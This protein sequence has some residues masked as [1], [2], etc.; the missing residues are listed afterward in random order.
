MIGFDNGGSS[1]GGSSGL[2]L[3]TTWEK[4]QDAWN[5]VVDL[6]EDISEA[7]WSWVETVVDV[8]RWVRTIVEEIYG[9]PIE[10]WTTRQDERTCPQCGGLDGQTWE[11]NEGEYPPAH[12]NCRCTREFAYTEWRSREVFAWERQ[13]Q[14]IVTGGWQITGWT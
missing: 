6:I 9:V 5:D 14:R 8:F 1:G 4:L 11:R 12:N 2:D 3:D 13:R 10:R 7:I